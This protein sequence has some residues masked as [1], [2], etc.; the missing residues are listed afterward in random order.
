MWALMSTVTLANVDDAQKKF[1]LFRVW[2]SIGW[3]AAGVSVSLLDWDSSPIVGV[4]AAGIRVFF[5][6]ACFMMP[7]TPPQGK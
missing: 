1:P 5:G 2:G 4:A 6:L 7:D 3:V